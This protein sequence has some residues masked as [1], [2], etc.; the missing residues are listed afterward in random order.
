M[1]KKP[2]QTGRLMKTV[3]NPRVWMDFEQ[4]KKSTTYLTSG[5]SKLFK[6]EDKSNNTDDFNEAMVRLG[7]S[8]EK[9]TQQ[10]KSLFRL[11]IIMVVLAFF[12]FVYAMY[13]I[14]FGHFHA[15]GATGVIFMVILTLAFR[16]HFWYYQLATR[17]L[18]CGVREWFTYGFLGAKR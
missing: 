14:Y 5:F 17:R 11:S 13:H 10:K 12:V 9:L 8:E 16:Y 1:D 15:A 3:F 2:S 6:L 7:L 4:L 18:G